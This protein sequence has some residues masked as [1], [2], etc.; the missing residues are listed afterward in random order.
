MDHMRISGTEP[1][2]VI[3]LP[4][5]VVQKWKSDAP[6]VP[7]QAKTKR[8]GVLNPKNYNFSQF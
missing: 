6:K 2:S 5:K 7:Y 3:L 1:S 8:D 4:N